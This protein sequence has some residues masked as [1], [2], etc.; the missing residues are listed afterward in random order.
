MIARKLLIVEPQLKTN[1]SRPNEY[2]D[3]VFHYE[4]VFP[5]GP[6]ALVLLHELLLIG[7]G[8]VRGYLAENTGVLVHL[9]G[10]VGRIEAT[11]YNARRKGSSRVAGRYFLEEI[12]DDGLVY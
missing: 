9:V 10:K 11:F 8:E 1:V 4:I 7:R 3:L 6:E 12:V 5:K 2:A